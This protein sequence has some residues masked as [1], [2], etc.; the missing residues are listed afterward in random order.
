MPRSCNPSPV[1]LRPGFPRACPRVL[2]HL[3]GGCPGVTHPLQEGIRGVLHPSS[4]D[5]QSV[6][7]PQLLPEVPVTDEVPS[8]D[9]GSPFPPNIPP[10][11]AL[12]LPLGRGARGLAWG[13]ISPS[14]GGR[15][16][17]PPPL[18]TLPEGFATHFRGPSGRSSSLN[19]CPGCPRRTTPLTPAS[20][21]HS[22][23]SPRRSRS[24]AQPP[25]A[26]SLDRQP[27]PGP[28]PTRPPAQDPR[29]ASEPSPRTGAA[30]PASRHFSPAHPATASRSDRHRRPSHH[31]FS[32]QPVHPAFPPSPAPQAPCAS[33]PAAVLIP[34]SLELI[35]PSPRG[36][37]H[38]MHPR[39]RRFFRQKRHNPL[40]T[41]HNSL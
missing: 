36:R 31:R 30:L 39:C 33:A 32:S 37:T 27:T 9:F 14:E 2:P 22:N 8:A 4:K 16:G 35:P 18:G 28:A 13:F 29:L 21:P 23:Q 3:R 7:R 40:N 25:S 17:S 10:T 38:P 12:N 5:F 6:F 41:K 34:E 15:P 19:A 11:S 26:V 20:A 1:P 24:L